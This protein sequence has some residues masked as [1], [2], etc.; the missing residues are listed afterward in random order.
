[1]AEQVTAMQKKSCRC[2]KLIQLE[3]GATMAI[4]TLEEQEADMDW[5]CAH[6]T[7]P[8]RIPHH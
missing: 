6:T 4:H 2:H 3:N 7:T 8:I 1:M 5:L